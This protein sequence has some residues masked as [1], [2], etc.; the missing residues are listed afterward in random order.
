MKDKSSRFAGARMTPN[1]R[2]VQAQITPHSAD[3]AGE[4]N[5]RTRLSSFVL[6][7]IISGRTEFQL[8]CQR[9]QQYCTISTSASGTAR[10]Q[11]LILMEERGIVMKATPSHMMK[12]IAVCVV[13][14]CVAQGS[15]M[16]STAPEYGL[17]APQAK[18]QSKDQ[19][20][21]SAA[22][23]GEQEAF[24]K[25]QSAPDVAAK[26]AAAGEFV[27]KYPKSLQRTEVVTYVVREA[28]K[29]QDGPQRIA[30]LENTL[31]VFKE[32]SDAEVITPILIDAYLKEKRPD[33]AFR[34]T[35]TYLAKNPS[36]VAV[37]T[38][39]LIEGAEQAKNQNPKFVA[40]SQQY[41]IKAIELIEGGKKPEKFDDAKWGE[42]KT[43]WLPV[44][45]QTL[46]MLALM[47]GNKADA[48]AKLDKAVS[49]NSGDPFTYVLIGTMLNEDYEQIAK[50][51]KTASPGPLKDAMLKQAHAKMDEVIDSY[52]HAVGLSEGKPPYKQ[53]HDQ[54]LQDLQS[55]YA[56]RHGGSTDGMQQ[57]IDKYKQQ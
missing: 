33:D 44:I 31:T 16:L 52:A 42:F 27:K 29:L 56:Y 32:P 9:A 51:Y 17:N 43:R 57:L 25:I 13:L 41:G 23:K 22:T 40:Q 15:T 39:A 12:A 10:A 47:T 1:P 2:F 19:P 18:D 30:Q 45:Y 4:G 46:G 54:M 49:L 26:V 21:Q 6:A 53:L 8:T 55:Y 34:I 37:L 35:A 48:R 28:E 3:F 14:A 20:K 24:A 7:S 50:E 38:Q 5:G 11:T 36:D